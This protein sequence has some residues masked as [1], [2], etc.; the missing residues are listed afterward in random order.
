MAFINQ[1]SCNNADSSVG[2]M[3]FSVKIFINNKPF[4]L[5]IRFLLRYV[6]RRYLKTKN[7]DIKGTLKLYRVLLAVTIFWAFAYSRIGAGVYWF[8]SGT[9]YQ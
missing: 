2:A 1:K 8:V 3:L 9:L 4:F 6:Y 7:V 5:L